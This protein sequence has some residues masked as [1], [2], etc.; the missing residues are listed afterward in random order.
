MNPKIGLLGLA[1]F[2][3]SVIGLIVIYVAHKKGSPQQV[4][5]P[6]ANALRTCLTSC[7]PAALM[8]FQQLFQTDDKG[9]SQGMS[10]NAIS[11]YKRALSAVPQISNILSRLGHAYAKKGQHDDAIA[12]YKTSVTINPSNPVAFV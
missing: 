12:A 6:I 8:H 9:Y 10:N 2:N 3:M 7:D 4:L 5:N 11:V 1:V